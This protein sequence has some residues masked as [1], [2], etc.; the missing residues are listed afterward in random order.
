MLT[1][2][3]WVHVC[4]CVCVCVCVCVRVL[5]CCVAELCLACIT[6]L[7]PECQQAKTDACFLS[8][9]RIPYCTL[10]F[11]NATS[12]ECVS[13]SVSFLSQCPSASP[14]YVSLRP[15]SGNPLIR[16]TWTCAMCHSSLFC[17][18]VQTCALPA[19][20]PGRKSASN[21]RRMHAF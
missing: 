18:G 1:C 10:C 16:W 4:L 21:R 17:D 12:A 19:R 8:Q 9:L 15:T 7:S 13:T 3:L 5:C 14:T 6:P 20:T 11:A 2:E